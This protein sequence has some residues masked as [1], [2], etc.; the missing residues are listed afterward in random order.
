MNAATKWI[1]AIVGLLVANL[2]AMVV[3]ATAANRGHAQV[4]P[5]YYETA[6]RFDETLDERARSRA[7]GWTAEAALRGPTVDVV[8]RDARGASLDGARV[9]VRGYQR[10]HAA[11]RFDVALSPVGDGTYRGALPAA[12]AGVH[13]V[14]VVV[15]RGGARFT[16]ELVVEAR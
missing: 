14:T 6:A 1:L 3:L 7:L 9:R 2:A 8:V 15:E 10:A 13:D 12:H 16:R 5:A 4:I 11:A